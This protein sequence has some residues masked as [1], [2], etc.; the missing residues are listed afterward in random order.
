VER[1]IGKTDIAAV[2][3]IL[4]KG[5]EDFEA[6]EDAEVRSGC[7]VRAICALSFFS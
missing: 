4:A 2:M 7:S 5:D 1:D 3:A 6:A